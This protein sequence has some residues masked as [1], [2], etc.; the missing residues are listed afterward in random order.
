MRENGIM[1][2]SGNY[3]KESRLIGEAGNY[4]R[5]ELWE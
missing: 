2:K 3:G 5:V 1:G 4:G